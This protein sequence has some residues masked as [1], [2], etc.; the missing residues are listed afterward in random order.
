MM[1]S[2]LS[3]FCGY[4]IEIEYMIVER[5]S[6]NIAPISDQLIY[7]V[8]GEYRNEVEFK[9]IAWSNELV[10]HVI[11]LKTNGPAS[12]LQGLGDFFQRNIN[13]INALLEPVGATL[14]PTGAHPWLDPESG[15]KLWP[16]HDNIIY[17][18]YDKIFDCRGHGWSNLQSTHLNLPFANDDEFAK[19]HTAIRLLL[20]IIPALSASSPIIEGKRTGFVDTRLEYYRKNQHKI[21]SVTGFVIPEVV[22]SQTEYENAI[23]QK[24]YQDISSF[25]PNK[26]LQEEWLNSRGAIARFDRNAI[27]IRI[28]DTQECPAADIAIAAL[29][30]AVL[31]RIIAE[32]WTSFKEQQMLSELELQKIFL[33]TIKN[34]MHATIENEKFL[35][36]LGCQ[37][38]KISVR[39]LW[40]RLYYDVTHDAESVNYY[41]SQLEHIL[42]YGNLSERI[43]TALNGQMNS[44]SLRSVYNQLA[45]CLQA[46]AM[47]SEL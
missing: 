22:L 38:N 28:L 7:Q 26:I 6:L 46:G 27:E 40:W 42:Q 34:G 31:K 8:A 44:Q 12:K 9:E 13:H 20:P 3:L 14:M 4:G 18:T 25:D 17:E 39:D 33:E 43:L 1:Q 21:P 30:S 45:Q 15:I 5:D 36:A 24:M 37:K 11:E 19:L 41:Q 29:L 16:H 23:L 35:N 47:F 10:L 2:K 32:S